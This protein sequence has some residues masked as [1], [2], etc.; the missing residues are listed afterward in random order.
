[1]GW[2]TFQLNLSSILNSISLFESECL[3]LWN[4]DGQILLCSN[5]EDKLMKLATLL[6]QYSIVFLF[7][8]CFTLH[9][10]K[11]KAALRTLLLAFDEL[12]TE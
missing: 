7:T 1:M 12:I 3:L 2:V 5:E 10:S 4:E 8:I 6:N 9:M 11:A